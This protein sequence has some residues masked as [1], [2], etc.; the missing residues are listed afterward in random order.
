MM[1]SL[2]LLKVTFSALAV[3]QPV[4]VGTGGRVEGRSLGQGGKVSR[5]GQSQIAGALAKICLGR[6]LDA[7]SVL[8]VRNFIEVQFEDLVLGEFLLDFNGQDYLLDFARKSFFAREY[9]VAD[10]LLRDGR[11][12]LASQFS[13]RDVAEYRPQHP[14]PINTRV[15]VI[16]FVLTGDGSLFRIIGN[17]SKLNQCSFSLPVNFI[18]QGRPVP[19]V[20]F[21]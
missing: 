14:P 10:K 20:N 15:V 4:A 1:A 9:G 11:T 17:F 5:F 2:I 16:I 8:A 6:S 21:G 12:A 13:A 19:G 18:K 3:F 7:V